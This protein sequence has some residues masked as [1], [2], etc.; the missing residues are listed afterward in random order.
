MV[1]NVD[2]TFIV[3]ALNHDYSYNWIARY[4]SVVL[5]G[6]SLPVVILTKADQ[7]SNC[8]RYFR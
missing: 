4:V 7:C 1:A 3:T 2:Y 6:G 8:G 5:Q